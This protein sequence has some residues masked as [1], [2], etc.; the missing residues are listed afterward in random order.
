MIVVLRAF[1]ADLDLPECLK[2]L[3]SRLVDQTW[4]V[5]DVRHDRPPSVTAGFTLLLA[6]DEDLGNAVE[7]ARMEFASVEGH[8]RALRKT[9]VSIEV[10]FSLEVSA[11]GSRSLRLTP[12]LLSGFVDAQIVVVVSAYPCSEEVD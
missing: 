3:P 10:D 12:E 7:A 6:E 5:G 1:S 2:L 4:M 11:Q 9:G 8:L